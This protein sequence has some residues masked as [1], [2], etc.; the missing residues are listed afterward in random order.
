M[1]NV[2]T[3]GIMIPMGV[4][5]MQAPQFCLPDEQGEDVCLSDFRGSWVLLYFYP[6]DWSKN[7]V[8]QSQQ[9]SHLHQ[10][11]HDMV[12]IGI[13][14]DTVEDHH[15]FKSL[16]HLDVLLLSDPQHHVGSLYGAWSG[17]RGY[18]AAF[19]I[20]PEGIIV[21]SWRHK[22]AVEQADQIYSALKR[23]NDAPQ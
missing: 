19:L 15:A 18:F 14:P 10:M 8:L 1:Q 17:Q 7:A 3:K 12:V 11:D 4:M 16:H 23:R 9:F 2:L 20:D 6:K 13:S 21:R 5:A 22:D